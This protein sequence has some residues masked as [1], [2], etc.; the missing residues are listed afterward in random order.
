[1]PHDSGLFSVVIP[2]LNL[3]SDFLLE[4]LKSLERQT[5]RPRELIIVN[6]GHGSVDLPETDLSVVVVRT[7]LRA[8]PAQSRN[9]GCTLASSEY[10]VFLDDD[11]LLAES[12]LE[13]MAVRIRSEN[14]DCIIGR[15][16]QLIGDSVVPF[17]NA[18]GLLT[19]QGI[20][21]KNP[22]ITGSSIVVR[23]ESFINVGGFD[24]FLR[25]GE[26]KALVL[27]MIDQ[28]FEVVAA[29]ECQAIARQHHGGRITDSLELA[30]GM[31]TFYSR[32]RRQ[33]N[34]YQRIYSFLRIVKVYL[35][36]LVLTAR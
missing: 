25:S 12:Y 15:L 2:T 17:K 1:M 14:L 6:N 21:T 30:Q 20:L 8:G 13:L 27:E 35:R 5:L 29:P 4:A 9:L 26:D 19:K 36:T 34:L 31:L 23:R 3:R 11:D 22:G 16:D 18:E 7:V 33:M 24:V 10:V 28:G 32:Y